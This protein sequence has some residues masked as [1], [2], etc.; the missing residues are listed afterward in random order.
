MLGNFSFGDYFKKEAIEWAWEFVTQVLQLPE[1]RLWV[2]IYLE[3]DEAFEI[4]HKDIGLQRTGSSGWGKR[5]ISGRSARV[6]AALVRRYTM[7]RGLTK[8]AENLT[9]G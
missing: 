5:I 1:E 2:S 4:W 9:A 3:D 7:I 8:G 6:P